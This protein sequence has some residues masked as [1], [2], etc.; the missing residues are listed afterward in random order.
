MAA[1]AEREHNAD[2]NNSWNS[3]VRKL[4]DSRYDKS[5]ALS[6]GE[7]PF[8][9]A[10]YMFFWTGRRILREAM[11]LC[12]NWRYLITDTGCVRLGPAELRSG[13]RIYR[14]VGTRFMFAFRDHETRSEDCQYKVVKLVGECHLDS[15]WEHLEIPGD[16]DRLH[17]ISVSTHVEI[18]S[19]KSDHRAELIKS[20][21][22]DKIAEY[23]T[24]TALF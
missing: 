5:I 15:G 14:C 11:S 13:D 17:I 7:I 2:M 18:T 16:P 8:E 24:D 23:N 1:E 10:G 22:S 20:N 6:F 4:A 21:T 19:S 3:K 12:H 9:D